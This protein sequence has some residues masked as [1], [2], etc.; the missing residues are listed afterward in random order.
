MTR[1][2]PA[3]TE[4]QT[5]TRRTRELAQRARVRAAA[6]VAKAVHPHRGVA[7]AVPAAATALR[8]GMAPAAVAAE[9][10]RWLPR[11]AL[12]GALGAVTIVAPLTGFVQS[13]SAAAATGPQVTIADRLTE[14]QEVVQEAA[15]LTADPTAEARAVTTASRDYVREALVCPVESTANGTL[16]AVMDS[17]TAAPDVI[18]PI[19]EGSYRLTSSYGYRTYPFAGMHEGTDFAGSLGTPLHAV[20]DGVV[21]YVGGPRDGRTGTIVIIQATVDG[22][23]VDFWYG[24]QYPEGPTVSVGQEVEAGDVIGAIGNSG[25]STGPHLHFEVHTPDGQTTVDP[26]A[27]LQSHGAQPVQNAC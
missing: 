27:W 6:T 24:H 8:E 21:T 23:S 5:V 1:N 14:E 18:M 11:A 20:A 25:R 2:A 3:S 7:A 10:R 4:S 15:E 12:V 17:E 16:S 19:A 22:Q 9:T 13:G 26:L